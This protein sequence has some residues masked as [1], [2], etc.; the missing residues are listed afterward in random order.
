VGIAPETTDADDDVWIVDSTPV[1]CARSRAR[2]TGHRQIVIGD[3]NYF[4]RQFETVPAEAGI[5][6]PRSARTGE[7]ARPRARFFTPLRQVIESINDT[8]GA[9][10]KR[11][12]IAY[13]HLEPLI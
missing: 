6:L 8:I 5:E 1:E 10:V 4:G 9:P 12:L 13:D 2:E 3:K 11:S 7:P